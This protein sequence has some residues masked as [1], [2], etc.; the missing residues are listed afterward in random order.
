MKIKLT[1]MERLKFFLKA[2]CFCWAAFMTYYLIFNGHAKDL[3]L[4]F[5]G[6]VAAR[7]VKEIWWVIK[8]IYVLFKSALTGNSPEKYWFLKIQKA[9]FRRQ[10]EESS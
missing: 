7:H 8:V 5:L 2:L 10:H 3:I 1:A 9:F 6:F 4:T